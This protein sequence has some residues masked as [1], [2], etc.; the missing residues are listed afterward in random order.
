MDVALQVEEL[1]SKPILKEVKDQALLG[2]W[3]CRV[4]LHQR[5]K[6]STFQQVSEMVAFA[7]LQVLVCLI[8]ASFLCPCNIPV[9]IFWLFGC[10]FES[11]YELR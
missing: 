8:H 4:V 1:I 7:D 6:K 3:T 11:D 2:L 5:K 9:S 10:S